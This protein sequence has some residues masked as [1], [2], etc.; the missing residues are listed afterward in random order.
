MERVTG[1]GTILV[2]FCFGV[3]FL[4]I[5]FLISLPGISTPKK[6]LLSVKNVGKDFANPGL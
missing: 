3:W 6:S 2:L 1:A 4:K 5:P